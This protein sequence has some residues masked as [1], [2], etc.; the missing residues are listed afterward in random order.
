MGGMPRGVRGGWK[1]TTRGIP[2]VPLRAVPRAPIHPPGREGQA[3]RAPPGP[4]TATARELRVREDIECPIRG[5]GSFPL[6]LEDDIVKERI[7]FTLNGEAVTVDTDPGRKL[8]WVLR[9][10][11]ERT[12]TKYGCGVGS[13][14]SCTVVVDGRAVRSCITDLEFVR[15]KVVLTIEGLATGGELHPLQR[16]FL[17]RGGYQ[18]GYCTPGMIMNAYGLLRENGGAS[19]D[20]IARGMEN[21]LCR[22]SAYKRIL[23]AVEAYAGT[24]GGHHV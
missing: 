21:N 17:E 20:E 11:L 7:T 5:A 24:V 14:G 23:E 19:R 10:D 8:L 6:H 1:G 22:C 3:P 9:T 4:R 12:G 13:C 15:G 18:C 2:E 16:E